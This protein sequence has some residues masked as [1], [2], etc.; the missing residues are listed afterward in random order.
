[1]EIKEIYCKAFLSDPPDN[2]YCS[3]SN[4]GDVLVFD[5]VADYFTS[6]HSIS[7]LD[8]NKIRRMFNR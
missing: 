6:V 3:L 7:D 8:K 4:C 2:Y 5:E 1:M